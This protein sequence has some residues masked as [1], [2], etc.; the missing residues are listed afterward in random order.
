VVH[1]EG[2][3]VHARAVVIATGVTYRRLGVPTLDELAGDGVFYG[4]A[5]TAARQMEGQDVI[6][7]GGGNSAGQAAVHLARFARSVTIMVRRPDL[8]A[9]MSDY[10]I[11]EIRFNPRIEV[12]GCA[13]VV[14]G[15][16]EGRLEWVE[17]EDTETGERHRRDVSG[18]F[19]LLGAEPRCDWLPP[20]VARDEFGFVLTGRDVPHD[21]WYDGLPPADLATTVPGIFAAGD[22]RSGSMK[23]V[24]S[25]TGEGAS[26]VS[27]VHAHLEPGPTSG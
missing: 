6:V 18:L 19:L 23:R 17:V 1:T 3:S 20:E 26:V 10:L 12:V 27:L 4:A 2:G 14:D 13:R 5:M 16:G 24:A 25:A 21:S 9:T 8:S 11:Q 7:V 15:G 22:I